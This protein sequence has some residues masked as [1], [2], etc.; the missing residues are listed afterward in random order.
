M[1]ETSKCTLEKILKLT[2]FYKKNIRFECMTLID[3]DEAD[4]TN[5]DA[6]DLYLGGRLY[7]LEPFAMEEVNGS[8]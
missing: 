1:L 7:D 6:E 8:K 3:K 5:L 2:L 4:I